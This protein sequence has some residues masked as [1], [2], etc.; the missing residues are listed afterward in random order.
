M[1]KNILKIEK[2]SKTYDG[3]KALE[4]I[5]LKI[6]SGEVHAIVGENGSGKSTLI[7]IISG[8]VYP[9]EGGKIKFENHILSGF[10]CKNSIHHGIEVIYQDLTL[11]SNLTVEENIAIN[12][13]I[14]KNAQFIDWSNVSLI[15]KEAIGKIEIELDPKTLVGDLPIADKQ[16]VA[17]VRALTKG[18]KVIIMDEPTS[19]LTRRE[20]EALFKIISDLKKKGITILFISHKLIEVF[21]IADRITVLR[22]GKKIGTFETKELDTKKL[23]K[24]M[25]GKEATNEF[26]KSDIK[27]KSVLLEIKNLTKNNQYKNINIKLYPNEIIG[28]IGT[29]GSGRTELALSIFGLNPPD[30]GET[31]VNGKLKKKLS[32]STAIK[33]GI[34]LVPENRLEQGLISNKSITKNIVITNLNRIL[35]KLGFID[36]KAA[37][38]EVMHWIKELNIVCSNPNDKVSS[39]SGGNQQK[40]V[41]SKWLGINP[42]V[43]ILDSPTVGVDVGAK[44]V[45]HDIIKNLAKKGIGIILISDEIPEV[46]NNCNRILIMKNGEIIKEIKDRK[47]FTKDY[48]GK[49]IYS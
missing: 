36:N 43:L 11:Y 5:D 23:T 47:Y 48:I 20:V 9:D 1:E 16:I 41:L 38:K 14:E 30:S 27:N 21:E 44:A 7:K 17:I 29:L 6:K 37:N 32:V 3:V 15:A 46:I 39:L 22:N 28:I 33:C 12:Q 35:N 25:V 10:D 4:G 45:I 8:A 19:S 40:I 18:C 13:L 49:I 26:Y 2:I 31:I 42:M 24:L 34:G